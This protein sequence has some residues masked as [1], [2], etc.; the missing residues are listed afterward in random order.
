MKKIYTCLLFIGISMMSFAQN[1]TYIKYTQT[2]EPGENAD[3]MMLSFLEGSTLEIASDGKTDYTKIV[4]GMMYTMEIE[5][6]LTGGIATVVMTG[7]LGDMAFRGDADSLNNEKVSDPKIEFV[8]GKKKILGYK[9][10][11]AI[12][13]DANGNVSTY[14]Y[15]TK[16]DRIEG[17]SQSPQ[18][19]PGLSLEMTTVTDDLTITYTAE[20]IKT[21]ISMT[22][23]TAEIPAGVEVKPLSEMSK[24]GEGM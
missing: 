21:T 14:W 2:M 17:M 6:D 5:T 18:A 8:K 22:D 3:Q 24:I 10:K 12:S 19:L 16:L 23:Y 7:M 15:T 20:K 11:K 4:F 9:C 13:T 1:G